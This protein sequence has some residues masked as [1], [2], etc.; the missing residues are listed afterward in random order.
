MVRSII[1]NFSS[2][3]VLLNYVCIFQLIEIYNNGECRCWLGNFKT[4]V[5]FLAF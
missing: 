3:S 4:Q 1:Y 5:A 2:P